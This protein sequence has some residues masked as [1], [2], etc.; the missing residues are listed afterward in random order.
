M[1]VSRIA[2]LLKRERAP[3][4]LQAQARLNMGRSGAENFFKLHLRS[5]RFKIFGRFQTVS[6][7]DGEKHQN[8]NNFFQPTRTSGGG[9]VLERG[10]HVTHTKTRSNMLLTTAK[11]MVFC[12]EP[13]V[14]L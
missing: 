13:L 6:M 12:G 3:S 1:D 10:L 8:K 2:G 9:V 4:P 5:L 7:C 11:L 14:F